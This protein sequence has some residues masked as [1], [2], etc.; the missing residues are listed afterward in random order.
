[1]A[2][3]ATQDLAL[4]KARELQALLPEGYRIVMSGSA[5]EFEESFRSLI[6]AMI[7]G[8]IVA[9][10]VLASQFNSF[11]HPFTV[12]TVVPLSIAGAAL[13]LWA[14]GQTLN[15]FSMIGLLL[16][17]GIAMKN[18]IILVD[19]TN[20]LRMKGLTAREAMYKAAPIRLRPI[21][22]TSFATM[23]AAVP[24][25]LALGPGGEIRRP[26]ALGIIGGMFVATALSLVVVPSFYILMDDGLGWLKRKLFG[27]SK[28]E[29]KVQFDENEII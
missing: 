17:F 8:L 2:P 5:V 15:M 6:F 27:V 24:A 29:P 20:Q 28:E 1:V 4:A 14:A 7:L 3:G 23:M 9:Y 11:W 22:M 10:M 26:M 12:L 18:S 19:Y 25:A 13:A 16:L 21:L